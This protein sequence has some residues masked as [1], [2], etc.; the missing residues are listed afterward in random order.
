MPVP[1]D[2]I[3]RARIPIIAGNDVRLT[4]ALALRATVA[5]AKILIVAF[6]VDFARTFFSNLQ[7]PVSRST[8][9]SPLGANASFLSA[10]D[11]PRK[12]EGILLDMKTAIF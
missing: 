7:T 3:D 2:V 11:Q 1:A 8:E 5:R 6:R 4:N 12:T 10:A 9:F